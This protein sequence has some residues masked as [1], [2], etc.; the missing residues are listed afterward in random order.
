MKKL[1]VVLVTLVAALV[2]VACDQP[3]KHTVTFNSHGGTAVAAVEVEHGKTITAPTNPTLAG[4]TFDGWFKEADYQTEWI[5]ATDV[6]EDDLTL[7]AKWELVAPVLTSIVFEGVED[8]VLDFDTPFNV[9]TGVR[10]KGN[11]NQYYDDNITYISTSVVAGDLHE[12]DG[13]LDPQA[14]GTHAVRYTVIVPTNA[15]NVQAQVW[16]N[17]T[18]N[19]PAPVEGQ[20][21]L[22]GD[23][24]QG[25]AGWNNPG[26]NYIADG[27][28]M[29]L[30]VV[31]GV[32]V[33]DVTAGANIYTPR[34]GQNNIPFENG[35]TYEISF[36]AKSSVEKTI[37]LQVGELL[38][39]AP[40][41][42]D[43][44]P[45]ISIQ[46]TITTSWATYSYKFTMNEPEENP[47]GSI[48]FEL[49]TWASNAVN[50]IMEFDN[51]TI[52]ESTPDADVDGPVLSGIIAEQNILI[53]ATYNPLAGV[54]A[55]DVT[56]GDVT[57][58]IVVT[59][60]DEEDLEVDA[61]D[62]SA[63]GTFRVVYFVEDS[64]GNETEVE[65]I[66]H[67][68][69]L[70]FKDTNLLTNPSFE[71]A[72][73]DP[74]EWTTWNQN[75]TVVP[76]HDSEAGTFSLDIT[77]GGDAAWAVQFTRPEGSGL[78]LEYGITYKITAKVSAE[79]ARKMNVSLGYGNYVEYFRSNGIDINTEETLV[80]FV[81]TNLMPTHDVRMTFE[82]GTQ[83]GFADGLV[84]FF[85]VG[86]FEL[87]VEPIV[88]NA[89]FT[90]TGWRGFAEGANQATWG[91]VD[92]EYVINITKVANIDLGNW[93]LQFIQDH[94]S[95]FGGTSDAGLIVLEPSTTYTFTF[96][97]YASEAATINPTVV[98][99]GVWVNYIEASKQS[100][101]ITDTKTT[102]TANFTTPADITGTEILKFEFGN[103]FG[104]N[105]EG[106]KWIKFDNLS[107][108][109]QGETTPLASVY[110]GTMDQVVAGHAFYNGE[111][112]S[113][114]A[115]KSEEGFEFTV[116]ALGAEAFMPHYYYMVP[117][118]AAGDYVVQ[119]EISASVA[120]DLRFNIVLPDSGYASIL[121]DSFVDFE[122]NADDSVVVTIEFTVAAP[123]T[124]VKIEL[125]FG[126]LGG[127]ATSVAGVFTLHSIQIYQI[128][129]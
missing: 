74:A 27:A 107:V 71:A 50:A 96:D 40:W 123:L 36:D 108:V 37:N 43:F 95:V 14:V 120:R 126:T 10:A 116:A 77:G 83:D 56:D 29:T 84:T 47:R 113:N 6:V 25:I 59:V 87:D 17:I 13:T 44:K 34:F 79:V 9:L 98:V 114:V 19:N 115:F 88:T 78:V 23:F 32:L 18:I 24:S 122:V 90:L 110:N 2:L 99:P 7:H 53:D 111:I 57:A 28:A 3:V 55:F 70:L 85:E 39:A 64:L 75:S 41:F 54:S 80:E 67:V 12:T 45:G 51:I 127:E 119:F 60:F 63:V 31:E 62:T 105:F 86:V 89:D 112:S 118:L 82:L 66:V 20:M 30:E 42:D 102:Y 1:F 65:A 58:D 125:D 81:F 38:T 129:A 91:I 35:K 5:F 69:D 16:R 121:P 21:L 33:V 15:G 11:D 48:L 117:T 97:A 61:V 103:A 22:N 4:N 68:V 128:V 46:R 49:G 106:E 73:G 109:K 52:E 94:Q 76:T 8:V 92:G 26:V 124:N 101:A 72:L 104:G 100:I 93:V